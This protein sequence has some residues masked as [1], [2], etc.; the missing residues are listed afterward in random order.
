VYALVVRM[1]AVFALRVALDEVQTAEGDGA[2]AG[3]FIFGGHDDAETETL[4]CISLRIY[5]SPLPFP[6]LSRS[7]GGGR[8]WEE[9][10]GWKAAFGERRVVG[11]CLP[12]PVLHA[13]VEGRPAAGRRQTGGGGGAGPEAAGT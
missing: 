9:E 8:G 10:E 5:F 7:A 1:P 4:A 6:G 12:A 13:Q 11:R 2:G 3:N